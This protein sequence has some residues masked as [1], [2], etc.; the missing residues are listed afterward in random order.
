MLLVLA[1]YVAA[2]ATAATAT[3]AA[4]KAVRTGTRGLATP[5][6]RARPRPVVSGGGAPARAKA[7]TTRD[8]FNDRAERRR[9]HSTS[10]AVPNTT[11]SAMRGTPNPSTARS[12]RKP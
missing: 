9:C 5:D 7:A 3:T 10:P 8:G 4:M 2:A 6:G 12:A 1:L 11:T